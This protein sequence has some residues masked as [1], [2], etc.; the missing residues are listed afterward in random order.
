MIHQNAN[1]AIRAAVRRALRCPLQR[2][3][4]LPRVSHRTRHRPLAHN[5]PHSS[6][7]GQPSIIRILVQVSITK[8]RIIISTALPLHLRFLRRHHTILTARPRTITTRIRVGPTLTITGHQTHTGTLTRQPTV[9]RIR[10]RTSTSLRRQILNRLTHDFRYQRI[11]RNYHQ[12]S[13]PNLGH[14]R[15]RHIFTQTRTRVI[16]ISCSLLERTHPPL[17]SQW[18]PRT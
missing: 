2:A 6:L 12:A 7:T 13:S 18:S 4:I 10:V 14:T 5:R 11:N 8:T 16:D 17:I 3:R 1:R 15:G 9:H